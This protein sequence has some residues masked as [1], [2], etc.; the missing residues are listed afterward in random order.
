MR[1]IRLR[2]LFIVGLIFAFAGA[3]EV[4]A[5]DLV[6]HKAFYSMKLGSVRAGSSFV[7]ARGNMGLSMERTCDGWTMSQTL[8][9]DLA[10]PDGGEI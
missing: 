6:A 3:K 4:S 1:N 2:T 9:M 8:R 10:T 5:A 7:G